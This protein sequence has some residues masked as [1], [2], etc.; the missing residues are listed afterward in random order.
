MYRLALPSMFLRAASRDGQLQLLRPKNSHSRK[1]GCRIPKARAAIHR[2]SEDAAQC[3][4][5]IIHDE[6]RVL[7]LGCIKGVY[8][9]LWQ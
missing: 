1:V 6:S 4:D 2:L 8:K 5:R 7:Q 9:E 3:A